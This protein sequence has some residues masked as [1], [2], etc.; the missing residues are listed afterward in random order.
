MSPA[1]ET[2]VTNALAKLE[3]DTNEFFENIDTQWRSQD[4]YLMDDSW[5]WLSAYMLQAL[6]R[7]YAPV[8]VE[9]AA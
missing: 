1:A 4:I 2:A 3:R 9:V 6:D 7:R 5:G 8:E